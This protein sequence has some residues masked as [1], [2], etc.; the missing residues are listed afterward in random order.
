MSQKQASWIIL[1]APGSSFFA[2]KF[3]LEVICRQRD[4][5]RGKDSATD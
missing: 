1:I 2:Y 4:K 3:A 5:C